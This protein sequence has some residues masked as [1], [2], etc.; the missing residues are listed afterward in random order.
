[1]ISSKIAEINGRIE[2]QLEAA[3]IGSLRLFGIAEPIVRR[4]DDD[5]IFPVIVGNDGECEEVFTD[6]DYAVGIYHK[7]LGKSYERTGGFG[8]EKQDALTYSIEL[9]CWAQRGVMDADRLETLICGALPQWAQPIASSF[10]RREVFAGEF[11]GIGFFLPENVIL[12]GMKY[13][14]KTAQRR[15]CIGISNFN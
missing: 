7:L 8:D 10:N 15:G 6:D 4:S 14:I 5:E 3:G 12:W 9:V 2:A 13:K 11:A 1:M